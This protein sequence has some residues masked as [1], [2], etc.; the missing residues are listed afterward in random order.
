MI[1]VIPISIIQMF[2]EKGKQIR[3]SSLLFKYPSQNEEVDHFQ[4]FAAESDFDA[5]QRKK[6]TIEV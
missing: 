6:T 3:G 2:F 4:V 5:V 1:I